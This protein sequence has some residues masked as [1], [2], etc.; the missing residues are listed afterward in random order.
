[1]ENETREVT[2]LA[3]SLMIIALV[4][5]FITYGF[6][7]TNKMANARNNE[8]LANEKIEQYREFNGYDGQS[9]IGDDVIELIRAKY[10]TGTEIFVDYRKNVSS[11]DVVSGA[12]QNCNYCKA[13]G[14]DHRMYDLEHYILHSKAPDDYNYFLLNANAV[15][16]VRNDLRN[17]FPTETTYRAYLVYN[18]QEPVEF[19]N[20]LMDNYDSVKNSYPATE[21][22]KLQA[23]DSGIKPMDPN[24]EV[25]GIV[26]VSYTT[27]G[28]T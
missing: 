20:A 3:V 10:D 15:G 24:W 9:L 5:G 21:Q 19:Y 2:Y 16:I 11:G 8:V 17:W 1:M 14:G 18:S 4:I 12:D 13:A 25:T 23:L 26:L 28:I 27:L 6:G 22:G 7:I